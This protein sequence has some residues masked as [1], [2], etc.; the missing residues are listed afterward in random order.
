M[1]KC[2]HYK[3]FFSVSHHFCRLKQRLRS[4]SKC[5]TETVNKEEFA[6]EC[7]G[8]KKK[9]IQDVWERFLPVEQ[10]LTS[11]VN[12]A[13]S[14][15]FHTSTLYVASVWHAFVNR[16]LYTIIAYYCVLAILGFSFLGVTFIDKQSVCFSKLY[17]SSK[18]IVCNVGNCYISSLQDLSPSSTCHAVEKVFIFIDFYIFVTFSLFWTCSLIV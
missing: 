9:V 13:Y 7:L 2:S 12:F 14:D 5:L 16:I 4:P 6:Q 10:P 1:I 3:A 17:W 15:K 18:C 11:L 8:I